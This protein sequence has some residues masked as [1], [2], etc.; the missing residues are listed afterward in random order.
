[1]HSRWS[2]V[3]HASR[4]CCWGADVSW[5]WMGTV[6]DRAFRAF[7]FRVAR[8]V[9]RSH[10]SAICACCWLQI[11][12][13]T[14]NTRVK[15]FMDFQGALWW[16]LCFLYNLII[17]IIYYYYLLFIIYYLLF[18]FCL[19][20]I[21]YYVLFIICFL[22]NICYLLFIIYYLLLFIC[23]LLFIIYHFSLVIYY[24][25]FFIYYF[26]FV[27]SF[28]YYYHSVFQ[29]KFASHTAPSKAKPQGS[30]H[31]VFP[32]QSLGERIYDVR[33]YLCMSM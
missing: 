4:S 30:R 29:T 1:M 11:L 28:I 13:R 3:K 10:P 25:L 27:Y 23:Y 26:S 31:C 18:V 9:R 32:G 20:F 14:K 24:L 6:E 17:I 16:C 22:F 33:L 15:C 8:R 21:I 5:M 7:S 2:V 12:L 19:L